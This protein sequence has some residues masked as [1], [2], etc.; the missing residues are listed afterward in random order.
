MNPTPARI[1]NPNHNARAFSGT[2]CERAIQ[3]RRTNNRF[4]DQVL[5]APNWR[6]KVN[7]PNRGVFKESHRV[8]VGSSIHIEIH[9]YHHSCQIGFISVRGVVAGLD[10]ELAK[11]G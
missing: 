2:H 5:C 11:A 7:R 1:I 4:P 9:G 8:I 10:L 6:R 3:L